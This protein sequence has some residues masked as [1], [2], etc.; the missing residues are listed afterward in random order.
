[1]LLISIIGALVAVAIPP[2]L[3]LFEVFFGIIQAYI[4][5]LLATV[6]ISSATVAH[7]SGHE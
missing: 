6:F 2:F 5:F 4:F 1:V 3:Y 7:M